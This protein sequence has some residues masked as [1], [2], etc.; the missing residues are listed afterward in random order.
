MEREV[1]LSDVLTIQDGEFKPRL[2]W[3]E[4]FEHLGDPRPHGLTVLDYLA[5]CKARGVEFDI[6][7]WQSKFYASVDRKGEA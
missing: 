6:M 3:R 4:A 5:D 1:R 7:E 2:N